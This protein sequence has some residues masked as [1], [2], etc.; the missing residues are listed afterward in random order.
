MPYL[1]ITLEPWM[2]R[3]RSCFADRLSVRL[4]ERPRARHW[5]GVLYNVLQFYAMAIDSL[6]YI[7]INTKSQTALYLWICRISSKTQSRSFGYS[8]HRWA[9]I[10][11]LWWY[12]CGIVTYPPIFLPFAYVYMDALCHCMKWL[13]GLLVIGKACN[14]VFISIHSAFCIILFLKVGSQQSFYWCL[15]YLFFL[16]S[17]HAVA[18]DV[19]VYMALW[20]CVVFTCC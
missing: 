6:V 2:P 18:K 1:N 3:S 16:F 13:I 14:T 8:L 9:Y 20:R 4:L 12:P 11:S 10:F 19:R 5:Q 7:C 17:L 15:C